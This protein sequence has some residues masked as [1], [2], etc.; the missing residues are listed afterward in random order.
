[1]KYIVKVF[2]LDGQEME[3]KN[4]VI[5]EEKEVS[6]K[7]LKA[8]EAFIDGVKFSLPSTFQYRII[9]MEVEQI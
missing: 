2:D 1:M 4:T 3:F 9:P 5:G 6:F 8:A 7:N